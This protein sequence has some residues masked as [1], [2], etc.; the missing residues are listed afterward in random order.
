MAKTAFPPEDIREDFVPR[1]DYFDP[2]FARC[3][4]ENLWPKVWQMACRLEEIPNVGDFYTYDILGDSIIVVRTGE[5][6]ARAYHNACPHRGTQLTVGS[7]HVSRFVCPFHGWKFDLNGECIDIIDE[8]DWGKKFCKSDAHLPVVQAGL[9]GGWVWINMDPDCQPLHDFLEPM[10]TRFEGF[11]LENLR[12]AWYKST[13]VPANWKTVIEAF[14]EFY[15]VQ[16][17]HAQ[18]LVYTLDYSTSEELGRHSVINYATSSGL[19]IGRSPRLPPKEEPDFRQYIFEYAEQFKRDLKAMQTERAYQAAQ[20][21]RSELTADAE[22][23]EVLT[24]WGGL[25]YEAAIKEG[26]GWPAGATPERLALVGFDV[27]IFPNFVMLPP[28]VEAVLGYRMRPNGDDPDSCLLDVW[29]LERFAP[30]KAPPLKREWA[31]DLKDE[32]WPLIL[33]Q[34]FQNLIRVQRGMHSR[35]FKGSRT[36]PLQERAVFNFHRIL[37]RF[38]EDPHADDRAGVESAEATRAGMTAPEPAE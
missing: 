17:T 18:M 22:P 25:V 20:Q 35:G 24:R 21:L 4:A 19:P 7:G 5:T 29:S 11:E 36:N 38:M 28:A 30:G 10:V 23:A 15:H 34:D 37:R 2:A 3:E 12:Y 1:E 13:I 27:H 16:T 33:R 8:G 32:G 14:N 31:P 26:A 6:E 9:W